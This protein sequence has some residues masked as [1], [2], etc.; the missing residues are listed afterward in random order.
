[1]NEQINAIR[2]FENYLKPLRVIYVEN[3][4]SPQ[5][6]STLPGESE[7]AA[8]SIYE[9]SFNLRTFLSR[10]RSILHGFESKKLKYIP[11]VNKM[12]YFFLFWLIF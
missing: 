10:Q 11:K 7:N 5:K 12:A 2:D 3:F 9:K 4:Y 1:M 8:V 6:Q